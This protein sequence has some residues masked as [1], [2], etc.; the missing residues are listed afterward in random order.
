MTPMT[1]RRFSFRVFQNMHGRMLIWSSNGDGMILMN[2]AVVAAVVLDQCH[3]M[4]S[5]FRGYGQHNR[6]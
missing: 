2:I 3:Y 5:R 4:S 1:N 6:L